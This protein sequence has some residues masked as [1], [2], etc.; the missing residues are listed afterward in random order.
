MT[1]SR[2]CT[3]AGCGRRHFGNGYCR[4]HHARWRRHGD[5]G[6]DL[7][8][9]RKT[10]GGTSYWSVHHRIGVEHGPAA[11]QRCACG[12]PARD[13]SYDGTDPDER[14]DPVRGYRYSLDPDHYLP[15]CRSCHRRVTLGRAAPRPRST[16]VVDGERAA[17]LYRAGASAPGIA[18]L[19]GTSR[20][21][22]YAA[23][24]A[25]RV[26]I[27]PRGTRGHL[28]GPIRDYTPLPTPAPTDPDRPPQND[29]TAPSDHPNPP[30]TRPKPITG[31]TIS[32]T[33]R[34]DTTTAYNKI[35]TPEQRQE[36]STSHSNEQDMHTHAS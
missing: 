8:I 15:R 34:L 23:L 19:L 36:Q 29:P 14:T 13:W 21:A 28:P 25:H 22:V 24:R 9:E 3:V 2:T 4:T 7:P 33:T 11:A 20:T 31:H 1:A 12:A 18:A 35:H 32:T 10:T 26:E 5:P 30:I 27:R 6:A 17:R 16:S